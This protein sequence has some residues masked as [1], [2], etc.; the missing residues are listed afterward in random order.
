MVTS[1]YA[2]LMVF[3]TDGSLIDECAWFAF[4]RTGEGSY[5]YKISSSDGIF[6]VELTDYANLT[7]LFITLR[8][9]GDITSFQSYLVLFAM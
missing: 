2:T 4:H 7:N 3:Y 6:I 8:H 1:R 5:G 9:I